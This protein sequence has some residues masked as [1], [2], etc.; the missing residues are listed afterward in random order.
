MTAPSPGGPCN[1]YHLLTAQRAER[2]GVAIKI[3]QHDIGSNG[4]VEHMAT[5]L[6]AK[7]P[8]IMFLIVEQRH[9]QPL[10]QHS[11]IDLRASHSWQGNAAIILAG[12]LRL[13]LP[14]GAPFEFQ[15]IDMERFQYHQS[16][17]SSVQSSTINH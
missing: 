17:F 9:A 14:A 15:G 4:A 11:H 1:Y 7:R 13:D 6:G 3:G 16:D 8:E 10:R 2:E 5:R 12:A